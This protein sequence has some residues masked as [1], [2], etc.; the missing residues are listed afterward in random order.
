MAELIELKESDLTIK[1][2]EYFGVRI[3]GQMVMLCP[4]CDGRTTYTNYFKFHY[5]H[6]MIVIRLLAHAGAM[7]EDKELTDLHR[8]LQVVNH[9]EGNGD[10]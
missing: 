3:E 1:L 9:L 4:K 10:G 6:A 8:Q 5:K 7:L 2:G